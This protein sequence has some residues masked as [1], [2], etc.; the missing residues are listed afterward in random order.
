[1]AVDT[2]IQVW[3]EADASRG[4]VVTPYI[5]SDVPRQLEYRVRASKEGSGGRSEI[6]Q[7][8]KVSVQGGVAVALGTI[9]MTVSP[10]DQCHIELSLADGGVLVA[11]YVLPCPR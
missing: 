3:L 4:S 7:S 2:T 8:G 1:M 11:T 5:Q 6:T 10:Q 9:G